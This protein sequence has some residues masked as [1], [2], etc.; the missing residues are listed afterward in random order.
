MQV[1]TALTEK[2]DLEPAFWR[3]HLDYRGFKFEGDYQQSV[4]NIFNGRHFDE[5]LSGEEFLNRWNAVR[6]PSDNAGKALQIG[7]KNDRMSF[8]LSK[9][10]GQLSHQ[11]S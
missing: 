3:Q 8:T 6:I 1:M 4:M 2:L 10:V 5:V 11:V 9:N 7:L